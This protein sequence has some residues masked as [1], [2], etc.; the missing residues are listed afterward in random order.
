MSTYLFIFG[1]TSVDTHYT[2]SHLG[3]HV[4]AILVLVV[5]EGIVSIRDALTATFGIIFALD[6]ILSL[7]VY[8]VATIVLFD[9]RVFLIV[10]KIHKT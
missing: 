3:I 2:L 4:D 8:F 1:I 10:L 7:D 6:R 9:L 5:V